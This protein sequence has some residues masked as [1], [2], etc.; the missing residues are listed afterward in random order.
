[1]AYQIAFDLYENATQQFLTSVIDKLR[2]AIPL[3]TDSNE[4]SE[5]KNKVSLCN[6]IWLFSTKETEW[7]LGLLLF[8]WFRSLCY[9]LG[10][11]KSES[12]IFSGAYTI[13]RTFTSLTQRVGLGF[14]R[15][16]FGFF[17]QSK[18][19]ERRLE[20]L[21]DFLVSLY[22]WMLGSTVFH[23]WIGFVSECRR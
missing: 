8:L 9:E 19:V 16:F 7:A 5:T 17:S 6:K 10:S 4:D 15:S 20:N 23:I 12:S 14:K 3:I 11:L 13:T 21:L 2:I 1:M 18:P 22:W